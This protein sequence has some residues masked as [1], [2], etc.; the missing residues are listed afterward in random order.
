[1]NTNNIDIQ[2]KKEIIVDFLTNIDYK[3][4]GKCVFINNI[5]GIVNNYFKNNND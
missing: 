1:M 2:I 5:Y 3:E 4:L